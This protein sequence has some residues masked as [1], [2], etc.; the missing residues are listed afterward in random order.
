MVYECTIHVCYVT[1]HKQIMKAEQLTELCNKIG[2]SAHILVI[3][4]LHCEL[5]YLTIITHYDNF[6]LIIFGTQ[7]LECQLNLK[8]YKNVLMESNYLERSLPV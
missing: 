7:G 2:H 8:K 6:V 4:T 1:G 5:F 3:H